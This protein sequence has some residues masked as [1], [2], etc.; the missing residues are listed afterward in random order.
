MKTR[1][2]KTKK[3]G[4]PSQYFSPGMQTCY[5]LCNACAVL[6][7]GLIQSTP[8][9][10]CHVILCHDIYAHASLG[11]VLGY[12]QSPRHEHTFAQYWAMSTRLLPIRDCICAGLRW[13]A[14]SPPVN[15]RRARNCSILLPPARIWKLAYADTRTASTQL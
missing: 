6:S 14:G 10:H 1:R 13:P 3:G 4:P 9:G 7:A 11:A 5:A 2:S 15:V 12:L 8:I